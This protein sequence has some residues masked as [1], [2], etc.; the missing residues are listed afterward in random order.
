[1]SFRTK[2]FVGTVVAAIVSLAASE[3]LLSWR[4]RERESAQLVDRLSTAARLIA[5]ALETSSPV[6]AA[7]DFD[8]PAHDW[9]DLVSGRVTLVAPDGVVLGDS[10]QTPVQRAGL[11]N[12]ANRPEIRQAGTAGFGRGAPLQRHGESRHGVRGR[13]VHPSG[14]SLRARRDARHRGRLGAGVGWSPGARRI[15]RRRAGGPARRLDDHGATGPAPPGGD[16]TGRRLQG[17][18]VAGGSARFSAGRTGRRGPRARRHG[19]RAVAARGRPVAGPR[20]DRC[21]RGRHGRGRAGRG[22]RRPRAARQR[23]RAALAGVSEIVLGSRSRPPFATARVWICCRAPSGAKR[24][25]PSRCPSSATASRT[26]V[27][28]ASTVPADRGGGAVLVLARHQRHPPDRPH[29]TGLRRERLPRT[30]DAADRDSRLCG[31][32]G[33]WPHQ[34]RGCP[35]VR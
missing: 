25:R 9:G 20:P 6:A 27:A 5:R 4:L 3:R 2:V 10:T 18:R 12:H 17:R 16:P 1:M 31:G 7:N 30:A 29:A 26:I 32:A 19:T 28:R 11:D 34:F 13:A 23:R 24:T 35:G 21:D 8:T 14:G 15:R 22:P 33:R